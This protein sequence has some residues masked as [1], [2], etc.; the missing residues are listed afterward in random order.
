[1]LIGGDLLNAG[2]SRELVHCV[3][4]ATL[5]GHYLRKILIHGAAKD[6]G[7]SNPGE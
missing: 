1:L 4:A 3:L 7:L 2:Y 5:C 6:L